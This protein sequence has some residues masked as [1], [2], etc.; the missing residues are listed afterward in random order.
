[1]RA[2]TVAL[3]RRV[4]GDDGA[5]PPPGFP[6]TYRVGP[7][8]PG[9]ARRESRGPSAIR[10]RGSR[11]DEVVDRIDLRP[12]AAR[13][14][15]GARQ[16]DRRPVRARRDVTVADR[17][18]PVRPPRGRL[19]RVR[20]H[21]RRAR[22][23]RVGARPPRR[24]RRPDPRPLR[25][26][27]R[28]RASTG[29]RIVRRRRPA[30][31][32]A[33]M[34]LPPQEAELLRRAS[35]FGSGGAAARPLR[36][37][38]RRPAATACSRAAPSGSCKPGARPRVPCPATVERGRA[39]RVR[40]AQRARRTGFD[41][42]GIWK[43]GDNDLYNDYLSFAYTRA[44]VAGRDAR[45]PGCAPGRYVARLMARRRLRRAGAARRSPS[46]RAADRGALCFTAGERAVRHRA[47]HAAPLG[48]RARGQRRSCGRWPRELA[49]RG[50]RCSC[51]R[52]RAR[53]SWCASRGG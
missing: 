49:G 26:A 19:A 42:I 4:A 17:P 34:E 6:D 25:R 33:L 13:R 7:P 23:V 20:L 2:P 47:G 18:V 29:W 31:D 43:R 12:G 21:A 52:R 45:S 16:R 48:G 27:A 38:A 3:P 46:R 11:S 14:R 24:A 53:P 36:R 51:S 39:I 50:H 32:A 41:W 35:R 10:S 1:M 40:V 5:S 8:R 28:R 44:R 15:A 22:V 30:A 9:R 37:A